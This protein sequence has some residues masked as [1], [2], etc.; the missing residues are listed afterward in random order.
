[1]IGIAFKALDIKRD[2][3]ATLAAVRASRANEA[4]NDAKERVAED[5][6]EWD[7]ADEDEGDGGIPIPKSKQDNAWVT[8]KPAKGSSNIINAEQLTKEQLEAKAKDD[9][10]AERLAAA[11]GED[12][13][14]EEKGGF[15]VP[16]NEVNVSEVRDSVLNWRGIEASPNYGSPVSLG[17][18]SDMEQH[19]LEQGQLSSPEGVN[20][21]TSDE[22]PIPTHMLERLAFLDSLDAEDGGVKL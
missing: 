9:E 5:F 6:D 20:T 16:V 12:I 14:E 4:A 17:I 19:L 13:G 7:L 3:R 8:S 15:E 11:V 2:R 18:H 21:N 10:E 22:S 1:M